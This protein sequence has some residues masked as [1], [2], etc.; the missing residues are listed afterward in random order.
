MDRPVWRSV[1]SSIED[2]LPL[3]DEV[4]EVLSLK[5]AN[6]AR[7]YA[8]R[9]LLEHGKPKLV[10]DSGTGP[11]HMSLLLLENEANV[12]VVALDYSSRLLNT[13]KGRLA[14]HRDRVHFV[15]GCF[16]EL[17]LRS[18]SFDAVVTAYALRDSPNLSQAIGE[19]ARSIKNEGCLAVVELGKPEN[20][21]KRALAIIYIRFIAPLISEIIISGRLNDNPWRGIAPT[22]QNLPPTNQLLQILRARF[23]VLEKREFLAGGMLVILLRSFRT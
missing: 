23:E 1:I 22:Y 6:K 12:E 8:T 11:G 21:F 14:R 4:N 3:Y 7:I 19:Y 2:A 10:L 18:R 15:R 9:R 5:R 16:E 20:A 13:C 17:P